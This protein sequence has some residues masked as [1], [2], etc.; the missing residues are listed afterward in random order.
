[1]ADEADR[2]ARNAD[3]ERARGRDGEA[4]A[5]PEERRLAGSVRAGDEE[6]VAARKVE[7]DI[8]QDALRPVVLAE[9]P[10]TEHRIA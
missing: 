5:E 2:L 3:V 4:R 6:E 1:M 8:S 9:A 10:G 7:V